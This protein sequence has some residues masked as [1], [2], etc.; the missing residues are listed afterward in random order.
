MIDSNSNNNNSIAIYNSSVGAEPGE[1]WRLAFFYT[2]TERCTL[3]C[4]VGN[5]ALVIDDIDRRQPIGQKCRQDVYCH[6]SG[7]NKKKIT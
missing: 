7:N 3:L 5:Q 2:N 6:L 4:S 1:R